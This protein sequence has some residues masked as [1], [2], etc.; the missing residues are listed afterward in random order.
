MV[1]KSDV[2][3][4]TLLFVYYVVT[5]MELPTLP[6]AVHAVATN[7]DS[8]RDE[9]SVQRERSRRD[10]DTLYAERLPTFVCCLFIFF[11]MLICEPDKEPPPVCA[12]AVDAGYDDAPITMR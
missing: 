7:T 9:K 6:P 2:A 5:P 1:A 10:V 4:I 11:T 3:H 12:D 8:E